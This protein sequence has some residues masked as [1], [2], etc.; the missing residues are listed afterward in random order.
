LGRTARAFYESKLL[1]VLAALLGTGLLLLAGDLSVAVPLRHCLPLSVSP[2]VR[3][4]LQAWTSSDEPIR[5][6]E[7]IRNTSGKDGAASDPPLVYIEE[8]G[9]EDPS[10]I[11]GEPHQRPAP[12]FRT[13]RR[14]GGLRLP[15]ARLRRS[16]I[17]ANVAADRKG[18]HLPARA[19]MRAGYR[20]AELAPSGRRTR[21]RSVRGARGPS[22]PMTPP[23]DREEDGDHCPEDPDGPA[24]AGKSSGEGAHRALVRTAFRDDEGDRSEHGDAPFLVMS[25]LSGAIAAAF[26]RSSRKRKPSQGRSARSSPPGSPEDT[27]GNGGGPAA[28]PRAASCHE[29]IASEVRYRTLFDYARDGV[30][31]MD[32]DGR[33]IQANPAAQSL[34]DI[35]KPDLQGMMFQNFLPDTERSLFVKRLRFLLEDREPHT[36]MELLCGDGSR[37]PAE[38]AAVRLPHGHI[39]LSLRDLSSR[40][41]MEQAL[42]Q[43]EKLSAIGRIAAAVAHELRNPLFVISNVLFH[44]RRELDTAQP[45]ILDDLRMAVEENHRARE[46]IDNLLAFARPADAENCQLEMEPAIRQVLRLFRQSFLQ[47][48]IDLVLDIRETGP[49]H[50]HPN[51]F[52]QVLVNLLSN[53]MDAMSGGGRLTISVATSETGGARLSITDTG[54]GMSPEEQSEIF[55]PFYSTK[56]EGRGTGLGLWIVHCTAVR[57]RATVSVHS[58]EES[59]STF[60]LD[61]APVRSDA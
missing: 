34:L 47:N 18:S 61:L 13:G 53:A 38:A 6:R 16:A 46:V 12:A 39:M 52:K 49:C 23:L 5:A 45:D 60:S 3:A 35:G 31:V 30:V 37:V 27:A 22:S 21:A 40:R 25:C 50:F 20:G 1:L 4:H 42:V 33:L 55:T 59:G 14:L 15:P 54:R 28:C 9:L 17:R 44:L 11:L 41:K 48:R 24:R 57:Y 26:T 36:E 7:S 32:S 29:L 19:S 10:E 8:S 56:K 43:G 58:V 2:P 51:A